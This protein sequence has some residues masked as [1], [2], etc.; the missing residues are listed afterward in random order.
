MVPPLARLPGR[1]GAAPGPP[2]F[3][4]GGTQIGDTGLWVADYTM[5]AENGGLSV[6]AHEYGHDLGLPDHYDTASPED[7]AV[8]W[9]TLMGQSRLRAG[10][11][12]G[13]GTRPADLGVWDKLALGWLDYEVA[14]AGQETSISL[15]PHEYNSAKPQALV[16]RLPPKTVADP[17]A[18]AGLG[19]LPVVE[20]LW[21]R[22]HERADPADRRAGRGSIPH[23]LDPL[24]HR[25]L[26]PERL[27]LRV[28]GGQR[29]QRVEGDPG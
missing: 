26:R 16:V 19:E 10:S 11:D 3:P 4:I 18:H 2:N 6:V 7:N 12:V 15:G 24:Q 27:R 29:R 21:E 17:A 9:W 5:Q 25:G 22:L 14:D 28:R 20:R 13:V 8:N 23:L 1:S